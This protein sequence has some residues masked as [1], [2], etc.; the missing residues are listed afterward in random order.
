MNT[1]QSFDLVT[2]RDG[3]ILVDSREVAARFGKRHD[4]VM[5]DIRVILQEAPEDALNFEEIFYADQYGR[6]QP[7]YEMTEDG[8]TDLV[9]NFTG[10]LAREWKRKY[11]KAFNAMREYLMNQEPPKSALELLRDQVD[12]AI[13]VERLAIQA[14]ALSEQNAQEIIHTNHRVDVMESKVQATLQPYQGYY[15]VM[16][17]ANIQRITIDNNTANAL[18]KRCSR[19]SRLLGYPIGKCPDARFGQVG[20]YHQEVL[21]NVFDGYFSDESD[22]E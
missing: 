17:Y 4:N 16:A 20:T 6:E 7:A 12:R 1:Q 19:N 10:D 18:G 8:F 15:S 21:K 3:R 13:A 2:V 5:R 22:Y 14:K 9:M 11:R